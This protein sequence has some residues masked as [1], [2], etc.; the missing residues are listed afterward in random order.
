MNE[1][2]NPE[3]IEKQLTEV[4]SADKKTA[5]VNNSSNSEVNNFTPSY[6]YAIGK[7]EL[8]FSS[9]S[10]E[11][12]FA[13]AVG[14]EETG[15]LTDRQML[16]KVLSTRSNRYLVRQMCWVLL[17]DGIETYILQPR[18]PADFEFLIETLR[19]EPST[20]EID[21]VIG[22]QGPTAPPELCGGLMLP[23]VLFD[24]V[25]SF[26]RENFIKSIPHLEDTGKRK[27]ETAAEYVF[28]RILQITNN[29]GLN[30]KHR[31]LNYLALRYP[32]IYSRAVEMFEKDYSLSAVDSQLLQSNSFRKFVDVFFSYRNRKT[33]FLEKFYVRVD[34]TGE[35]PFLIRKLASYYD[36]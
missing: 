34:V 14:K 32:E 11:N 27:F 16:R 29:A 21:V 17:I 5:F 15:G 6:V 3:F 25:Y 22:I 35:F 30:D 12:E 28:D 7:V 19:P 2:E 18:D 33:D 36:S 10:L 24:Q 26:D 20:K 1:F 8:R 9:Q 4:N 23:I 13:Q 31:A